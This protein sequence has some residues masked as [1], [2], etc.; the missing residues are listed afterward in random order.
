[1]AELDN[2]INE[3]ASNLDN[4]S[5]KVQK[6]DANWGLVGSSSSAAL[7]IMV[8]GLNKTNP[9]LAT[10]LSGFQKMVPIL[11]Q[12]GQ[13]AKTSGDA[14][15]SALASSGVGLVVVALTSMLDVIGKINEKHDEQVRKANEVREAEKTAANEAKEAWDGVNQSID[16]YLGLTESNSILKA[17]NDEKASL[18]HT[19]DVYDNIAK[20]RNLSAKESLTQQEAQDKLNSLIEKEAEVRK[21]LEESKPKV[22]D[23]LITLIEKYKENSPLSILLSDLQKINEA[24]ANG[25]ITG[26]EYASTIKSIFDKINDEQDKDISKMFKDSNIEMDKLAE[27]MSNFDIDLSDLDFDL[28]LETAF[29]DAQN[30]AQEALENMSGD[31]EESLA[32]LIYKNNN[33]LS[34]STKETWSS[35]NDTLLATQQI[36]SNVTESYT[37]DIERQVAAGELSAKEGKKRLKEQALIQASLSMAAGISASVYSILE[38]WKSAPGGWIGKAALATATA[39]SIIGTTIASVNSIKAAGE[40]LSSTATPSSNSVSSATGTT[41]VYSV[42]SAADA[43]KITNAIQTGTSKAA[44][45]KV[46]LVVEDLNKVTDNMTKAEVESSF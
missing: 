35:I 9:V 23:P 5:A 22:K 19:I 8:T 2:Q 12:I 36:M 43:E 32:N 16:E 34:E 40:G 6:L 14:L 27:S 24:F 41:Q 18:Q 39:A 17:I 13:A 42:S 25:K 33:I 3:I 29:I 11:A 21:K 44:D 26:T 7:G 4:L 30:V 37:A 28:S 15:K 1:M 10:A 20:R 31:F 38:T 46:V 45:S